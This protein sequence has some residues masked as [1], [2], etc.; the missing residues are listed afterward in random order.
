[1]S[2]TDTANAAGTA[3]SGR[4]RLDAM[5]STIKTVRT[6]LNDFNGSLSD[7]QKAQFDAIGPQRAMSG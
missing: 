2:G 5:L 6:A 4:Q 7:E 3:R 1:M